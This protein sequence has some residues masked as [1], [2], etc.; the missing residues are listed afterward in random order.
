[1]GIEVD[2]KEFLVLQILIG[3]VIP[4]LTSVIV[5]ALFI[6]NVLKNLLQ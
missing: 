4:L 2:K 5:I 3:K 6:N 1:M